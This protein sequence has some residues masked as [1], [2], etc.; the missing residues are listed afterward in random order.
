MPTGCINREAAAEGLEL[1]DEKVE[2]AKS[3]G[4]GAHPNIDILLNILNGTIPNDLQVD[5]D[6]E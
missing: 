1:Y 5:I 6:E 4:P 3:R 2:E